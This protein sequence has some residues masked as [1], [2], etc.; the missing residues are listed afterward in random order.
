MNHRPRDMSMLKP[1]HYRRL[2][3][4]RLVSGKSIAVLVSAAFLGGAVGIGPALVSNSRP[5]ERRM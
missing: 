4:E 1:K 2:R 3:G 5:V